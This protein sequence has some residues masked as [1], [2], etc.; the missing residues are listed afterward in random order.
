[1]IGHLTIGGLFSLLLKQNNNVNCLLR[2]LYNVD[3]MLTA[4]YLFI[5]IYQVSMLYIVNETFFI[6][7]MD[8][9]FPVFL[10]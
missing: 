1:M 7:N 8:K 9:K 5:Y 6:L 2:I 10:I 4:I 3:E